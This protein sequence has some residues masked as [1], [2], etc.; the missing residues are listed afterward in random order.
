MAAINSEIILTFVA[1]STV[2]APV[3]RSL[4]FDKYRI[5]LNPPAIAIRFSHQPRNSKLGFTFGRNDTCDFPFRQQNG[6]SQLHFHITFN[7]SSGCPILI[8]NSSFGTVVKS[9]TTGNRKL[10]HSHTPIFTE[11]IIQFGMIMLKLLL[12]SADEDEYKR[13]WQTYKRHSLAT[14]PSFD[15][16]NLQSQS[17]TVIDTHFLSL[18]ID[19]TEHET[20]GTRPKAADHLGNMYA[21]KSRKPSEE[22]LPRLLRELKTLRDITHVRVFVFLN[23]KY[24]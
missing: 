5:S 16:L 23:M 14:L 12:P 4:D 15:A 2:A 18:L 22:G 7:T 13:N 11:D 17:T 9:K 24:N 3:L 20:A 19:D 6:I 1:L 8:D 10:R 21:V